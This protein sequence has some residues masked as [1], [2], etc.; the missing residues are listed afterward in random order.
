MNRIALADCKHGYTYHITSRNLVVGVFN[1]E[2]R[3]FIGIREKFGSEF[4]FTEFHFDTGA[5][6]GTASPYEEI[7]KCP[8]ADLRESF[9][10]VCSKC[11][12]PVAF[13]RNLPDDKND[14]RGKWLHDGTRCEDGYPTSPMNTALFDYLKTIKP[15]PFGV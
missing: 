3:G 12:K 11:N 9:E 8:V 15:K 1:A 10:T 6:Y 7:G 13:V 5:P 2:T 14:M 4:L